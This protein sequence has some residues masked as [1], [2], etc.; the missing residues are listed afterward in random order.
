MASKKTIT[1]VTS[2]VSGA[3]AIPALA[4]PTSKQPPIYRIEERSR[5]IYVASDVDPSKWDTHSLNAIFSLA[6]ADNDGSSEQP[7]QRSRSFVETQIFVTEDSGTRSDES[8]VS[9]PRMS[10]YPLSRRLGVKSAPASTTPSDSPPR[11]ISPSQSRPRILFYHKHDPHYGFTNFSAHPVIYKGKRYPTS[12]HLFQSFKF[13]DHRPNLA[14]HIRTCSERPSVAFSEAR[15]FQPEIR[16]DWKQVNIQKMDETLFHKFTQH[17][18]LLDELLATG[19]AELIEDSDKDAFWGVGADRKGRNELGKCLERLRATLRGNYCHKKPK[20][21]NFD[22]CGK[23]CAALANPGGK[24]RNATGASAQPQAAASGGKTYSK[25]N[26]NNQ[27]QQQGAST[28]DP[29]QLAKLVAQHIPQ[30]QALLAPN[31]G[32]A[33]NPANASGPAIPPPT[34]PFAGGT[35][36]SQPAP[37]NNPFLNAQAQNPF[38]NPQ[39]QTTSNGAVPLAA[40]SNALPSTQPAHASAQQAATNIECLIPGCGKPVHVDAKGVK[41][42]DYCSMRHR[43]EAVTSGLVSPCIMCLAYPQSDTDYFCSRTCREESMNKELQYDDCSD[44]E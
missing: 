5:T 21:Q 33:M 4:S 36:A 24:A 14:E 20:F 2:P 35:A 32:G 10:I 12:E 30:V 6:E 27:Q 31:S 28:I 25:G 44:S 37:V 34:N 29:V 8:R 40:S 41:V 19:D 22:Y 16:P 38:A 11:R 23:N 18:D 39:P 13:Q 15:R 26:A 9:S 3:K 43:E 7:I 17:R 1:I 42:S